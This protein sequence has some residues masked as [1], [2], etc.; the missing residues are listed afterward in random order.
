MHLNS[1]GKAIVF[2]GANDTATAGANIWYV[3]DSLGDTVGTIEADDIV[4][5]GTFTADVD[6]YTAANFIF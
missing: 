6:A 2:S 1:G 5:V 3:D 4:S